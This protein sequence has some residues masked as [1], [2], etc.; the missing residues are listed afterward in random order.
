[1][2]PVRYR[3][4]RGDDRMGV[5]VAQEALNRYRLDGEDLFQNQSVAKQF[6]FVSSLRAN[7]SSGSGSSRVCSDKE[8]VLTQ[9]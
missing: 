4:E 3:D 6:R 2:V 1:M 8:A 5:T 7:S 9:S